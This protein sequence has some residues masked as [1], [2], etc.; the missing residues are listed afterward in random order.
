[1]SKFS[2]LFNRT[3]THTF[4]VSFRTYKFEQNNEGSLKQGKFCTEIINYGSLYMML[5]VG[6]P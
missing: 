4:Q 5:I 6:K 3:A 2:T 1:M